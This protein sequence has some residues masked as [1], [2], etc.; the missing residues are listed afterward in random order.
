MLEPRWRK[1]FR[2]LWLHKARLA[3]VVPAIAAGLIA[4]GTVLNTWALVDRAVAREFAASN[5][6]SATFWTDTADAA[7]LRLV[8]NHPGI[9]DAQARRVVRA[10]ARTQARSASAVL[11]ATDDWDGYRIGRIEPLIGVWPPADGGIVVERSSVDFAGVA[12]GDPV[13]LV[14]SGGPAVTLP[15]IGIARDVGV[16]PGWMEHVLYGFV[17]P[18]TLARLGAP[19]TLDQVQVAVIDRSLDQTA[20]GKLASEVKATVESTGRIVREVAVPVP[21]EHIHTDQ[22][23]SLLYTQGAFGLLALILSGFLVVNLVTAMLMG[24]LREI[25][26]MKTLGARP[27]QLAAMYLV[28][29]LVLGVA[30]TVV[31]L[32]TAALVGRWYGA[33]KAELLNFDVAGYRIPLWALAVQAAVGLLTPV[34]AAAVP[35][36]RGC[37]LTVAAA[38]RDGGLSAGD[39]PDGLMTRVSGLARPILLSLRNAF[40][41]RQRMALTLVT[42]ALGGAIFL[43]T[44]SLRTSIDR[45]MD[46]AFALRRF[47]VIVRFV[48]PHQPGRIEAAVGAVPGVAAVEAWSGAEAMI[49]RPDG[50]MSNR[51]TITAP[52][53]GGRLLAMNLT[54]GRW[55]RDGNREL[56]VTDRMLHDE[57]LTLESEATLLVSGRASRWRVVGAIPA[58]PWAPVA[59]ADR[60][61]V[62]ALT[63]QGL[64]ATAAVAVE[65]RGMAAELDLIQRLRA[66]LAAEGLTVAATTRLEE[67]RL[68]AEDHLL[69]VVDFLGV[70]GWV[71]IL[72]GGLALASTMSLAV[73]ERTREIGVLRAIGA[74]HGSILAIVQVEGLVIGLLSWL[75]SIPLS[76]P[77][78]ALLAAIFSRTMLAVPPTLLAR[79]GHLLAWLG[80][81]AGVSLVATAGPAWRATRTTTAAALAYE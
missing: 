2:D 41:R 1:V 24:Q 6:P 68:V 4:A 38:L 18:A 10:D 78:S 63:S 74:S 33:F 56:V 77:V 5:P 48:E 58:A 3:L 52:P 49:V 76:V 11:T 59:L 19:T 51:F 80:L 20:I 15:V 60:Q 73:L 81:V 9:A 44:G 40:R 53:A 39:S 23:N 30:A 12:I 25:G 28:M 35:V 45:G 8:R 13:T 36:A 57:G 17:T 29:A 43:A 64:V 27:S 50:A 22:M 61:A 7:L 31:A 65:A 72:V 14:L 79:P 54:A 34:L 26:V 67:A 47:E 32:P 71:T 46:R 55:P 37:R 70:M 75:L 21:G 62:A 66:A 69:T 42:L 16:A